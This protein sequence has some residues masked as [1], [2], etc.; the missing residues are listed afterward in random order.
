M[1]PGSAPAGQLS[2]LLARMPGNTSLAW[3][4]FTVGPWLTLPARLAGR[5]SCTADAAAPGRLDDTS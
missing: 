4:L 5:T 1:S 3:G 2:R